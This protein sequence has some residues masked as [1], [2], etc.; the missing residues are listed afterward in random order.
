MIPV[1]AE[2]TVLTYPEEAVPAALRRQ[3][4]ALQEDAWPSS[5]PADALS[6]APVHDPALCPLSMLLVADGTVLAALDVLTKEITHAGRR[7]AAGGLS[8]VVTRREA[9]GRGHGRR[10]VRTAREAMAEA[11]LEIGLFTCDRPLQ[12]FYESA[13]WRRLPGTVLVGGTPESPFPSDWSPFD[14]VTM[15]CF[16]TPDSRAAEPSFHD[17]RIALHSGR[18][19]KL[20]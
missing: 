11:G 10:L 1:P 6:D 7:W 19:D 18:I 17:S 9:R 3:V 12:A 15:A 20:W 5:D 14:K 13:G 4:R 16:F 2:A 8:T